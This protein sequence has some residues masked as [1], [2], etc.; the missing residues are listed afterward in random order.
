MTTFIEQLPTKWEIED[1]FATPGRINMLR[2]G[3]V[4]L[5][6]VKRLESE[7]L[8]VSSEGGGTLRET[9]RVDFAGRQRYWWL[10]RKVAGVVRRVMLSELEVQNCT[11]DKPCINCPVCGLLG[12]L[13]TDTNRA[14]ASRVKLQDLISV[15]EY[16]YD[17][18]FR[19]RQPDDPNSGDPTPFQEVIVPPGTRFPFIVRVVKPSRFDIGAFVY[20]NHIADGLGYGNYSKLR[21][22]ASTRWLAI[23]DGFAHV[24]VYDLLLGGDDIEARISDLVA[25]PPGPVNKG[26]TLTGD[27]LDSLV[28]EWVSS[29]EVWSGESGSA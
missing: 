17:E 24:S 29:K 2:E 4:T 6:G 1:L 5:I 3:V 20:A 25:D 11:V 13:N 7:A 10:A 16:E 15:E 27:T 21:G 28:R 22:D 12:G 26:N 19:V 23:F 14:L 8:F 18:K 9:S